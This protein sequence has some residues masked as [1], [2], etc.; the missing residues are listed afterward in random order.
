MTNLA[1]EQS[2]SGN[3]TLVQVYTGH[4]ILTSESRKVL[5]WKKP[6]LAKFVSFFG[7]GGGGGGGSG[8]TIA[9]LG[10]GGGGGSATVCNLFVPAMFL[11]NVLYISVGHGGAGGN[12]ITGSTGGYTLVSFS[13]KAF[14][15]YCDHLMIM[16]PGTGGSIASSGGAGG[17]GG[18]YSVSNQR[19]LTLGIK[20]LYSGTTGAT[21]AASGTSHDVNNFLGPYL[22]AGNFTQSCFC[23]PGAG[24]GG[25][26]GGVAVR[27]GNVVLGGILP[28]RLGTAANS[29]T[30]RSDDGLNYY[31]DL[32]MGIPKNRGNNIPL[33]F[34][35]GAGGGGHSS[36]TASP[37]GHGGYG[38]GGGGGGTGITGG[39]VGGNGGSGLLIIT[40]IL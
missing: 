5:I 31:I 9:G 2:S 10:G 32:S 3:N 23:G 33:M 18:G 15:A 38:S 13:D 6:R 11:P 28:T 22:T 1:Y 35:G 25:V 24:G 40:S 19:G 39:G 30:T 29:G 17:A 37:G 20:F 4:K 12:G 34:T 16:H 27:G 21:G 36:A 8:T 14:S 7:C 26:N